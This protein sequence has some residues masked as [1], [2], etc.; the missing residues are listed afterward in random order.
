MTRHP[1]RASTPLPA[2]TPRSWRDYVMADPDVGADLACLADLARLSTA[3]RIT[4]PA[5]TPDR[6]LVCRKVGENVCC[7]VP[8][9]GPPPWR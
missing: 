3:H 9:W 6:T 4:P 7:Y 8:A 2:A 5:P 1:W